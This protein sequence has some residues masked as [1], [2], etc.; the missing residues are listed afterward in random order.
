MSGAGT[1]VWLTGLPSAGKSS[2]A[3][4]AARLLTDLGL[5]VQIL[6]GDELRDTLCADLGFG[7]ADRDRNVLRIG[8]VAEL[9]A[10]NGTVALVPV[11]A[12]YREARAAVRAHHEAHGTRYL[13]AYV[14]TP[15]DVC[16][17]RDV[18]GLYARQRAGTLTGLT[19]VD[20]PYEVPEAPDVLLA[21]AG[22]TEEDSA[23]ELVATLSVT[24]A[25]ESTVAMTGGRSWWARGVEVNQRVA[26]AE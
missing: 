13:E 26:P 14:A 19:G 2:I 5:T 23:R 6:D 16:A 1:T 3:R 18:K 9:L 25:G 20:D 11:I 8:Y 15:V 17:N 7:K 4:C 10:R 22:R 12:P 21:T 24:V